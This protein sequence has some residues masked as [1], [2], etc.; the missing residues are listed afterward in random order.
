MKQKVPTIP[1]QNEN[2]SAIERI[3]ISLFILEGSNLNMVSILPELEIAQ[4]YILAAHEVLRKYHAEA[5]A[6]NGGS[7]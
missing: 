7:K 6:C 2:R 4:N 1:I 3:K 5:K